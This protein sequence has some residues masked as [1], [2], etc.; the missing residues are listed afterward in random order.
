VYSHVP[1]TD[2]TLHIKSEKD[3]I[4]LKLHVPGKEIILQIRSATDIL[5]FE[6]SQD[7]RSEIMFFSISLKDLLPL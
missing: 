4:I 6:D 1:G 5:V 7:F 2:I 3:I